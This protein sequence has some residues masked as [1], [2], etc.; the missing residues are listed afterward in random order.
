MGCSLVDVAARSARRAVGLSPPRPPRNGRPYG[1][2]PV[3]LAEELPVGVP[4]EPTE[5]GDGP[6][7]EVADRPGAGGTVGN[8]DPEVVAPVVGS[9]VAGVPGEAL[10]DGAGVA[11]VLGVAPEVVVEVGAGVGVGVTRLLV[12]AGRTCCRRST[13]VVPTGTGRTMR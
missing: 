9:C 7:V 10:D 5:E 12:G 1:V 8:D 6:G 4:A 13:G 11:L 3:Q 2:L